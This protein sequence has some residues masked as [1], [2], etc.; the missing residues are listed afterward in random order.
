MCVC[1]HVCSHALY[2]HVLCVDV[3]EC[4]CAYC[5]CVCV[6]VYVYARYVLLGKQQSTEGGCPVQ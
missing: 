5:V 2:V 3:C 4:V 1:V 6:C